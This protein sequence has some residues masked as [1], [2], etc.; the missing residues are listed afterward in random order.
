MLSIFIGGTYAWIL[1]FVL[2]F[3]VLDRVGLDP[4]HILFHLVGL[5]IGFSFYLVWSSKRNFS[6]NFLISFVLLGLSLIGMTLIDDQQIIMLL[7]LIAGF[8][9][10]NG[11]PSA[12]STMSIMFTNPE[13]NGRL[14]YS[15]YIPVSIILFISALI[16]LT[17]NSLLMA[18]FLSLML[19]LVV[20]AFLIGRK[21]LTMPPRTASL[22][23]FFHKK[24][25]SVPLMLFFCFLGFFFTNAYY[26]AIILLNNFGI[27][28]GIS[29]SLDQFNMTLWLTCLLIC[30]PSGFL[31]DKI[32][33]RRSILAGLYI[34]AFAFFSVIFLPI[35]FPTIDKMFLLLI[36]FPII[37]AIGL[38]L[39]FFGTFLM[40]AMELSPVGH[41]DFLNINNHVAALMASFGMIIG[42]IIDELIKHN[43]EVLPILM[44]FT[45]FTATYLV[46]QLKEP[47]PSKTFRK[48]K[49][50]KDYAER[51]KYVVDS[52]ED[53]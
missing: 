18:V 36:I 52:L 13:F 44:I 20:A 38:T 21:S 30:I 25:F 28:E 26:G 14:N 10:G 46:S 33:R 22:K 34:N 51:A 23:Q 35:T 31:Y 29:R 12:W 53:H 9:I 5:T 3:S 48:E 2:E 45:Y 7:L 43:I 16:D 6:I 17:G 15:G 19:V 39:T 50:L 11:L 41:K 37:M 47:L 27:E 49:E 1:H 4:Y 42:V 8:N 40:L 24:V 32:G